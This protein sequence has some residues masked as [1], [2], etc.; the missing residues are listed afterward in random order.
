MRR[1]PFF[2]LGRTYWRSCQD[3]VHKKRERVASLPL[4]S[5]HDLHDADSNV[6]LLLLQ[7][8]RRFVVGHCQ[9]ASHGTKGECLRVGDIGVWVVA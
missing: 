7:N 4:R 6:R 2:V 9:L 8:K 1:D 3:R 5:F